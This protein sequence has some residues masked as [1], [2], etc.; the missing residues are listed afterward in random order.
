[1]PIVPSCGHEPAG[2][3]A[4]AWGLPR[5]S[6]PG[7]RGSP[8][9]EG[10]TVSSGHRS[11]VRAGFLL[12]SRRLQEALGQLGPFSSEGRGQAG[13]RPL[14]GLSRS[15]L[16]LLLTTSSVPWGGGSCD[17][18]HGTSPESGLGGSS[19]RALPLAGG[20]LCL[21]SQGPALSP[22]AVEGGWVPQHSLMD[23]K[24]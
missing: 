23:Q 3:W 10:S 15:P 16:L 13:T 14:L 2:C 22:R 9:L 1:M 21:H 12:A 5:S 17:R 6:V 11:G 24:Y 20:L 19:G 8:G 7:H 4:L 18:T